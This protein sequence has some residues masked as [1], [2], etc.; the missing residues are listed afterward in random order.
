[1]NKLYIAIAGVLIAIILSVSFYGVFTLA[2]VITPG[3][4]PQTPSPTPYDGE[5]ITVTDDT[6]K[7]FTIPLPVT[8]IVSLDDGHTEL[9]C[10]LGAQD[11]IVGRDTFSTFP[12]SIMNVPNVGAY[13]GISMEAIV[14]LDPDVVLAITT[15]M[16]PGMLN[17]RYAS[18]IPVLFQD[19][20]NFTKIESTIRFLGKLVNNETGA[21]AIIDWVNQYMELVD[22][23]ISG[24]SESQRPTFYLG[25]TQRGIGE[26]AFRYTGPD[27]EIGLLGIKA[28]GRN[29]VDNSTVSGIIN[30]E[31]VI[32]KKPEYIFSLTYRSQGFPT[33][34]A[35]YKDVLSDINSRT[36]FDTVPAVKDKNVYCYDYTLVQG[37]RYPIGLL[38]FA[39]SLHPDLF[40]DIDPTDLLAEMTEKYFG[41]DSNQWVFM[42]P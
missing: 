28:G 17:F 2:N 29:I 6:G 36:G 25:G 40:S 32:E 19:T 4:N 8:R 37:L 22:S 31:F 12:P 10:A 27:S 11:L 21:E 23:R 33:S 26:S 24:L 3:S 38:Y 5:S 34:S 20:A 13:N 35:Y 16:S 14:Q 18:G 41:V 30:P 39:K 7:N 15:G 1:L 9:L 42:Y